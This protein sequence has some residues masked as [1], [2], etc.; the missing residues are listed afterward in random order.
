MAWAFMVITNCKSQAEHDA[1]MSDVEDA[2][3]RAKGVAEV[4]TYAG[5]WQRE[6][7]TSFHVIFDSNDGLALLRL[8]VPNI[9]AYQPD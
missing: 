1:R 2:V 7:V 9:E 6:S 3:C 5:R 4:C 8:M